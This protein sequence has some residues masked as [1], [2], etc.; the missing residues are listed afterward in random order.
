MLEADLRNTHPSANSGK[1]RILGL[2]LPYKLSGTNVV[3]D[4]TLPTGVLSADCSVLLGEDTMPA[5]GSGARYQAS[6]VYTVLP[7]A[8]TAAPVEARLI[9]NWPPVNTTDLAKTTKREFLD[10]FVTF[11]LP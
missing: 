2:R 6:V 5:T 7:T 1:S 10:A 11:A 9:V 3:L 4:D 8:G